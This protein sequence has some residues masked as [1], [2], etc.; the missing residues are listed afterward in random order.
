MFRSQRH[1]YFRFYGVLNDFL[2]R[3]RRQT[4][5]RYSFWGHPS[6][7]DAIEAQDI[8]HPEVD[9]ILSNGSVVSFDY[10]LQMGDRISVYPWIDTLQRP[11][12]TLRPSLPDPLRFICDVHLGRLARSLRMM[13]FDTQFS[14]DVSDRILAQ[15]SHEENRILLTRDRELL[16]RGRVRLGMYMRDRQPWKQAGQVV[17]WCTITEDMV[18]AFT[19]C[20]ECNTPLEDADATTVAR[21]VP[22]HARRTNDAFEYCTQCDT[23]YWEG[24][25]VD[26]MRRFLR[27]VFKKSG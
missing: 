16:K 23:V 26:R 27:D 17:R 6:V 9:L 25:H 14:S 15:R 2:P 7:K 18:S 1:A 13:G 3:V 24:T 12:G 5:L 21:E 8:P 4:S 19:R 20:L 22:T 11:N 10:N